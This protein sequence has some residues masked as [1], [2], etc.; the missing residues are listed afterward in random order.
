MPVPSTPD[1]DTRSVVA[2]GINYSRLYEYRLRGI[3]QAARQAVWTEIAGYVYRQMGGPAK[4]L[5]PGAGRCE[6]I[7]AIP[8]AER[9]VVDVLGCEEFCGPGV[10]TVPGS[11]LDVDLP[12]GHLDGV[13][14]SM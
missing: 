12:L 6:F 7:N 2:T 11:I 1:P 9:W 8:V 10:K 3:D 5:D 13:F 4:V 14:V